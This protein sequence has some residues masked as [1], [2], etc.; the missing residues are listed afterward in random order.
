MKDE[1]L[2]R[3]NVHK[4]TEQ[5]RVQSLEFRVGNNPE[6]ETRNPEQKEDKAGCLKR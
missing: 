5:F 6:P 1:S 2:K 3:Q 4:N